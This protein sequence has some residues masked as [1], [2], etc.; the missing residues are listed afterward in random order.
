MC[1]WVCVHTP[2]VW[3]KSRGDTKRESGEGDYLKPPLTPF[4]TNPALSQAA[5]PAFPDLPLPLCS[6]SQPLL[7]PK[8]R[9]HPLRGSGL[10]P[11]PG[12]LVYPIVIQFRTER[13][14]AGKWSALEGTHAQFCWCHSNPAR[15][16]Q[17]VARRRPGITISLRLTN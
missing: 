13:R 17:R 3:V 5:I 1:V 10:P 11:C 4:N 15:S 7:S 6:P 2:W 12:G 8:T 14:A 16:Q 9:H